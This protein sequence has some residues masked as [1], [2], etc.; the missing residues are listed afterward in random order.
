MYVSLLFAIASIAS[1]APL[2]G[3]DR[4]NAIPGKWIVKMKGDIATFAADDMKATLS[5]KP[6][7]DY[8]MPG[9]R[10]FA[11]T[12]SDEELAQL[13]ASDQVRY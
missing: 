10:G 13:Q 2:L 7:Y 5:K 8:S 12:L 9:F 11:G 1:A 3:V 4:R 6:D